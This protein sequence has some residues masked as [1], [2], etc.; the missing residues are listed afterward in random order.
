MLLLALGPACRDGPDRRGV[1]DLISPGAGDL[2]AARGGQDGELQRP[3]SDALLGPERSHEGADLLIGQGR[4]MLDPASLGASRQEV[5][6]VSLPARRV[7]TAAITT[8]RRP[9]E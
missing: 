4:E 1:V 5:L 2:A 3:R 7:L 6:Q 8:G 9:V